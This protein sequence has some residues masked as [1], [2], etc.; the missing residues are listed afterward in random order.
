MSF[1]ENFEKNEKSIDDI[2]YVIPEIQR[3][4]EPINITKIYEFHVNK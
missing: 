3:Q 2:N 1:I 4:V